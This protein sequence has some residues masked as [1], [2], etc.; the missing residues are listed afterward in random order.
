MIIVTPRIEED[1]HVGAS[2]SRDIFNEHLYG[3]AE[4]ENL[5][6]NNL[7]SEKNAPS[8]PNSDKSELY[9]DIIVIYD[10][11]VIL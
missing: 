11:I 1:I 7:I 10:I 4:N 5:E 9:N 6:T 3:S 2:T 8:I